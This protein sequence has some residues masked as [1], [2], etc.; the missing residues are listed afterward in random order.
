MTLTT[1]DLSSTVVISL[2]LQVDVDVDIDR[3][4]FPL[5]SLDQLV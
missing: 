3:R 4:M 1:Y 5:K 2:T